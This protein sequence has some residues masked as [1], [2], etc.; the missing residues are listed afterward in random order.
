MDVG[1]GRGGGPPGRMP[2]RVVSRV[3]VG[4]HV[5]PTTALPLMLA[6]AIRVWMEAVPSLLTLVSGGGLELRLTGGGA[7]CCCMKGWG[8]LCAPPVS[9]SEAF[10]GYGSGQPS[11]NRE[12]RRKCQHLQ[13]TVLC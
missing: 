5:P 9:V 3:V 7:C 2:L 11:Y 12:E 10:V 13:L 8:G 4:V 6:S 1:G